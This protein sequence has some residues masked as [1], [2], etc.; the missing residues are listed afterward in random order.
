MAAWMYQGIHQEAVPAGRGMGDEGALWRQS[1]S[2]AVMVVVVSGM[3]EARRP[4]E[5]CII[6]MH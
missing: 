1:Q 6:A 3:R 2:H 4:A 5:A